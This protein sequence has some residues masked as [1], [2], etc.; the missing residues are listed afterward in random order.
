MQW[1][2]CIRGANNLRV[3]VGGKHDIDPRHYFWLVVGVASVIAPFV[4]PAV[5][6][7]FALFMAVLGG[8]LGVASAFAIFAGDA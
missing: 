3:G 8:I 4:V 6:F 7:P 1:S 2:R 5:Y